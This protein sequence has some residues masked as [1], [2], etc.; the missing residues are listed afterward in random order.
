MDNLLYLSLEV[1]AIAS[2]TGEIGTLFRWAVE[3]S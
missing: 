2:E 1:V 3:R